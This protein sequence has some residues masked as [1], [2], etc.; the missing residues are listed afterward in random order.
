VKENDMNRLLFW[1]ARTRL[2][3]FIIGLLFANFSFALPMKRLRETD[4]LMAIFHPRPSHTLHILIVPKLKYETIFDIP[5]N[6]NEFT[7]DLFRTVKSLIREFNL[8][9]GAYRLIMNGGDYQEVNRLHFHLVSD[10]D[11]WTKR[12][13]NG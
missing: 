4:T 8:E 12:I 13:D 3:G 1:F 10:D 9:E 7:H 5:T 6:E 11:L 2:G